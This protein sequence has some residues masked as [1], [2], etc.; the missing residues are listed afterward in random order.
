MC[1]YT[2]Y[3]KN[4]HSADFP[5]WKIIA[6]NIEEK[7]CIQLCFQNKISCTNAFEMFVYRW[8]F[9]KNNNSYLIGIKC[10]KQ[11]RIYYG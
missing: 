2:F 8:L 1:I 7:T 9:M 11:Q 5:K 4:F 10:L 3:G 6:M